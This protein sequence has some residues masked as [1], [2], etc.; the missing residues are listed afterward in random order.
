MRGEQVA[1]KLGEEAHMM[2]LLGV[3]C[4]ALGLIFLR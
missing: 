4:G 1:K 2:Y 3:A